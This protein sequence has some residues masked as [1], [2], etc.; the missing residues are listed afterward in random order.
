[1]FRLERDGELSEPADQHRVRGRKGE[2]RIVDWG[3]HPVGT[4]LV[5]RFEGAKVWLKVE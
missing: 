5:L 4:E 3:E 2:L 1:M